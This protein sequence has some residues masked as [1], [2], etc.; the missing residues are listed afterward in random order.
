MAEPLLIYVAG[1]YSADTPEG[2]Q[3][4]VDRAVAAGKALLKKGHYVIVPHAMTHNWDLD[5]GLSWDCFMDN[6]IT[7][8]RKSDAILMLE[9]WQ[10]ST[11]SRIE[12]HNARL[13][14]MMM[15]YS[16]DEVPTVD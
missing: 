12:E 14:R 15:F 7:L 3:E 13:R 2:I 10:D 6:C 11:G 9:D 5:T 8:L 16:L 1:A 4:N